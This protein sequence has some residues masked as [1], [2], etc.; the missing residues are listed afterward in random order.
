MRTRTK[1]LLTLG[2]VTAL[3]LPLAA[4]AR[5][6]APGPGGVLVDR[7]VQRLDLTD[8]QKGEIRD[9][10]AAHKAELERELMAIKTTRTALWDAVHADTP[11]DAAIRS[12][13]A[14]VG[15]AEGDLGVTRADI[16]QEVRAVLTSEQQAELEEMAGD[17]RAFVQSLVERI[18]ERVDSALGG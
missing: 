14:A 6:P 18:R 17:L 11:N 2:L 4:A 13:A 12:A 3:A 8:E 9:I 7:A 5:R 10:L 16:V 15:K 1:V